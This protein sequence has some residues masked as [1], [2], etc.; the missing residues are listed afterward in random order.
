MEYIHQFQVSQL[1][2]LS[3]SK[4][5]QRCYLALF[6][7]YWWKREAQHS[8]RVLPAQTSAHELPVH[9]QAFFCTARTDLSAWL[10]WSGSRGRS[11]LPIDWFY[12]VLSNLPNNGWFLHMF[13]AWPPSPLLG[14]REA[15]TNQ[16][17]TE[18]HKPSPRPV[19]A[20]LWELS[21]EA[22]QKAA[23]GHIVL[24][25]S[26][27]FLTCRKL[28]FSIFERFSWNISTL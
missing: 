4:R 23:W 28:R 24:V 2:P 7:K 15:F 5:W 20:V 22:V 10:T 18:Q 27:Y 14:K 1:M 6:L 13:V 25:L 26:F 19:F 11:A 12:F 21:A 9:V 17:I 3:C 16:M 8:S